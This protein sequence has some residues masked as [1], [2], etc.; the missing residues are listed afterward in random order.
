MEIEHGNWWIYTSRPRGLL[1]N[2]QGW[3]SRGDMEADGQRGIPYAYL[4]VGLL[5]FE[6]NIQWERY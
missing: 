5:G 3:I 4:I 2:L 6:L 1:I